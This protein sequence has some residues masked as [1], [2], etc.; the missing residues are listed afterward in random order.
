MP[1]SGNLTRTTSSHATTLINT[2]IAAISKKEPMSRLSTRNA[3]L[4]VL[5]DERCSDTA[6]TKALKSLDPPPGLALLRELLADEQCPP[7]LRFAATELYCSAMERQ[8][9]E[10]KPET[11][12]MTLQEPKP[13]RKPL[14]PEEI[15]NLL[16]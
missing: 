1:K 8:P 6:R 14:S 15:K 2:L 4:R 13:E 7:K 5:K 10:A 11:R 16:G 9:K 3:W 12:L